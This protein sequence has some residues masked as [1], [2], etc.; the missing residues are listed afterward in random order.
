MLVEFYLREWKWVFTSM[1]T[2]AGLVI[3]YVKLG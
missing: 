2:I 3:A 1:L